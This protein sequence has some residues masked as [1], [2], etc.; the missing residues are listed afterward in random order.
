MNTNQ[1]KYNVQDPNTGYWRYGEIEDLMVEVP[2][3]EAKNSHEYVAKV[4][5]AKMGNLVFEIVSVCYV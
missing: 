2:W 5:T 3:G 1:I 4:F